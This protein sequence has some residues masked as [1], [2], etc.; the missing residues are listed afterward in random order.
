MKLKTWCALLACVLCMQSEYVPCMNAYF[1]C[2][3][4]LSAAYT[5][6]TLNTTLLIVVGMLVCTFF[7]SRYPQKGYQLLT[8]L[9][10][11]SSVTVVSAL[12][13]PASIAQDIYSH[14][15]DADGGESYYIELRDELLLDLR[16]QAL[17]SLGGAAAQQFAQW[18]FTDYEKESDNYVALT[19]RKTS[20]VV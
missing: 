9:R 3:V 1:P 10:D 11:R 14:E 8:T 17:R 20:E 5:E 19:H 12:T 13:T 6:Q 15:R 16:L 7:N 4:D 2:G 18:G